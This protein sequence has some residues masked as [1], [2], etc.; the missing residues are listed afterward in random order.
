MTHTHTHTKG[1]SKPLAA[2]TVWENFCHFCDCEDIQ[3]FKSALTRTFVQHTHTNARNKVTETV[4]HLFTR[5]RPENTRGSAEA[6]EKSI[7][8]RSE[9]VC[10]MFEWSL[11]KIIE[12]HVMPT[13]THTHSHRGTPCRVRFFNLIS[14][15]YSIFKKYIFGHSNGTNKRQCHLLKATLGRLDVTFLVSKFRLTLTW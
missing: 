7:Y 14:C 5:R 2:S 15:V 3:R 4:S 1:C 6:S 9:S 13:N 8:R 10:H 11:Q 12:L